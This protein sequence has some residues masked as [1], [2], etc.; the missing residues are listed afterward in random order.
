M[1]QFL[2]ACAEPSRSQQRNGYDHER[3]GAGAL[4]NKSIVNGTHL[5]IQKLKA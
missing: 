3:D 2:K 1:R 5:P 4:V